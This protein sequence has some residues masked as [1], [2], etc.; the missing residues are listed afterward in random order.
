M[1]SFS[2]SVQRPAALWTL[3]AGSS[4]AAVAPRPLGFVDGAQGIA[5]RVTTLTG[6]QAWPDA[7]SPGVAVFTAP[8]Q[9]SERLNAALA[10]FGLSKIEFL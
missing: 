1:V 2:T 10:S 7:P 8:I 9:I 4:T 6:N 5:R 3:S